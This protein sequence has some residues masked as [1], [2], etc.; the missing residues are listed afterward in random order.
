VWNIFQ[1]KTGEVIL[2][3]GVGAMLVRISLEVIPVEPFKIHAQ[4]WVLSAIEGLF[5]LASASMLLKDRQTEFHFFP[6]Q[7]S[8]RLPAGYLAAAH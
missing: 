1:L 3:I 6:M 4:M 7:L 2:C 5:W 8:I